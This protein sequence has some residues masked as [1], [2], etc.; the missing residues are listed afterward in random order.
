MRVSE[1]VVERLEQGRELDPIAGRLAS[2]WSV[3]LRS[4]RLRDLLSG[5][6]LGHP[7]H[8][9]AVIVPAGTLLS[10]T[11]LDVTG[12]PGTRPAARRLIG[13][14]L[15]SAAP[16]AAAGWADWLDTE[17]A[18]RRVGI[19]HATANLVGVMSYAAS[20][21]Q[22]RRG[23]S[24]LA[25]GLAGATALGVGGWLGGH[26]AYALGVGVDTTA[27]QRGPADWT[28]ALAASEV[29]AVPRAVDVDGA[30][31][32]LTRVNGRI[33]AIGNRCTHRGGPLADGERD[34]DRVT[35]PWHGSRFELASGEAVL[36]PATRPQPVY[37]VREIDGRVEIRR[38]E[39][40]ALRANPVGPAPGRVLTGQR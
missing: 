22:R 16:A 40:R 26:L 17:G 12:G 30:P 38:L 5:R 37:E 25:A 39:A 7:L 6:P 2:F 33:V 21:W 9:A 28:D 35:C 31:V 15:L 20:W 11:L 10:A 23:G 29:T 27:F 1:R 8:P 32:L 3:A 24:G 19:V 36:G 18:E 34:G 4:E 14:G 13:V